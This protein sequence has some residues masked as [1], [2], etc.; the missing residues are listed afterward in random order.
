MAKVME[1]EKEI[2]RDGEMKGWWRWK[3]REGEKEIAEGS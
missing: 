3:W 2:R 1:I